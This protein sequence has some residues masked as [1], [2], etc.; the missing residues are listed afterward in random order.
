VIFSHKI[1]HFFIKKRG[2][3]SCFSSVNSTNFSI[4]KKSP[5]D[6]YHK[7][8]GERKGKRKKRRIKKPWLGWLKLEAS[9]ALCVKKNPNF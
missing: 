8:G 7:F 2:E 1:C 3:I 5:N 6:L 4:L 9:K